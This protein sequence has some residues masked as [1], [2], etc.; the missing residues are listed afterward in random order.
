MQP[1][2][3]SK[4]NGNITEDN[5]RRAEISQELPAGVKAILVSWIT[6]WQTNNILAADSS[7]FINLIGA[8]INRF[9]PTKCVKLLLARST[10]SA[11]QVACPRWNVGRD[12]NYEFCRRIG[13]DFL[14]IIFL[15]RFTNMKKYPDH[16]TH[17]IYQQSALLKMY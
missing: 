6:L 13:C 5:A 4:D 1:T 3:W 2:H 8:H 17:D 9:N 7:V 15:V 11:D 12:E 14:H 10:R 16:T